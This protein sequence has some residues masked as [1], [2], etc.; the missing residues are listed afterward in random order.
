VCS[1]GWMDRFKLRHNI[2][3]GKVSGEARGVNNDMTTLWL[4]AVWPSVCEGCV[5]SDIF[6]ANE[7]GIFFRL[8]S[9]RKLKFK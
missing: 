9:D 6:N 4:F 2:S 3:F 5:D 1:V 8:T 7:T